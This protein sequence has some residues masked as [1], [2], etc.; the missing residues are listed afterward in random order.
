MRK[1]LLVILSVL[2]ASLALAS[3]ASAA[4]FEFINNTDITVPD[5]DTLASAS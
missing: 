1:N 2:I 4:P 5:N 3:T